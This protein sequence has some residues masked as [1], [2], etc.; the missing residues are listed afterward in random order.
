MGNLE[1]T[2]SFTANKLWKEG[3]KDLKIKFMIP[4]LSMFHFINDRNIRNHS[5][6]LERFQ[7][8]GGEHKK[9]TIKTW[10]ELEKF[11]GVMKGLSIRLVIM[12][13]KV[14]TFGLCI[15]LACYGIAKLR[16]LC[17]LGPK[18]L[19]EREDGFH[20]YAS[21]IVAIGDGPRSAVQ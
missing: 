8:S 12:P 19:G 16:E 11:P 14:G 15:N 5:D 7:E 9:V 10:S 13:A 6:W 17:T 2:F 4:D 20:G 3:D 18:V 21:G 1:K